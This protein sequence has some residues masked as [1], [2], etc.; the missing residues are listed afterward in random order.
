MLRQN[1]QFF[2]NGLAI[3]V[4]CWLLQVSNAGAAELDCMVKPEMYIELSSPVVGVLE[5]VFVNKGDHVS[6]GQIVAQLEA[7]VE[8]ARVNQAKLDAANN[9]DLNNRKVQFEFAKRN[10]DRYQG[11]YKKIQFLSLRRIKSIQR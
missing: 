4:S 3:F 2:Y 5:K 9:T 11:L 6:K 8:V 7:S 1:Q 10:Q